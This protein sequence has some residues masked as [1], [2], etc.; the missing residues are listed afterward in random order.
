M[1][2]QIYL[3]SDQLLRSARHFYGHILLRSASPLDTQE[4]RVSMALHTE[5]VVAMQ[6]AKDDHARRFE[7]PN[8]HFVPRRKMMQIQV[9]YRTIHPIR[10][11]ITDPCWGSC[12]GWGCFYSNFRIVTAPKISYS[13]GLA[14]CFISK[15]FVS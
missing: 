4:S 3:A 9:S 6:T 15:K 8:F 13:R 11:I 2:K 1:D 12:L 10:N 5:K 7:D 14:F